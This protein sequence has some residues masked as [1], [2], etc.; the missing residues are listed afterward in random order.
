MR[1]GEMMWWSAVR[2]LSSFTKSHPNPR[3]VQCTQSSSQVILMF[4]S[5]KTSTCLVG[6][7]VMKKIVEIETKAPVKTAKVI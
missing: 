2:Y 6:S 1:Q 7:H 3:S 5:H 4:S